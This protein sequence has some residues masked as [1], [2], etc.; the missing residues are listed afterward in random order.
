ML[1]DRQAGVLAVTSASWRVPAAEETGAQKFLGE[2]EPLLARALEAAGLLVLAQASVR[3][4]SSSSK[5]EMRGAVELRL[6]PASGGAVVESVCW[7]GQRCRGNVSF[8]L[9]AVSDT[10]VILLVA[11][12]SKSRALPCPSSSPSS[13][14]LPVTRAAFVASLASS[15]SSSASASASASAAVDHTSGVLQ[16]GATRSR[17]CASCYLAVKDTDAPDAI[18]PLLY[19]A[20]NQ[21]S[22]WVSLNIVC[23]CLSVCVCTRACLCVCV[24]AA[25][26]KARGCVRRLCV[27]VNGVCE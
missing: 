22:S 5:G 16:C 11:D 3:S 12:A 21:P 2:I 1:L 27:R 23:M 9:Q 15:S 10:N 13:A 24:C 4:S 7:D 18:P 17:T 14:P 8:A 26:M 6:N 19:P 25:D 20:G